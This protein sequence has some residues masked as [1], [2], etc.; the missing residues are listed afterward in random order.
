MK[1]K[2]SF[3]III[4][5]TASILSYV[6]FMEK[7]MGVETIYIRANGSVEPSYAPIQRSGNV[8]T[9]TNN[10]NSDVDGIIVER[11]F[12]ILDGA[13]F[14]IQGNSIPSSRG[15]YLSGIINSTVRNVKVKAFESGILL[16]TYSAYNRIYGNTVEDN[17]YGINCW[18]YAD[19]NTIIG[20]NITSN[21]QTG[22]WLAGSS[23]I[24]VTENNIAGNG[25]YGISLES[26][27]NCSVYHN[28]FN[29]N[30]NQV[31]IYDSPS[32]WDH[33]YPSGGNYWSDYSGSDI[34]SGPGQNLSG[35]DKIGDTKYVC[36]ADNFDNYPFMKL[37]V[38]I[39]ITEL[40]S[41]KYFVGEGYK[42]YISVTVQNQGWNAQTTNLVVRLNATVLGNITNLALPQRTQMTLNFTWQTSPA[43]RGIYTL[44]STV[45]SV[46]NEPDT[47][48]NNRTYGRTV[49]VTIVG[50]V[51]GDNTVDIFDAIIVSSAFGSVPSSANW[52][53]NAD[54]NSDSIV[55]IFDAILLA[56][57]FGKKA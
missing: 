52:N 10:I 47:T 11:N 29:D 50:D 36:D 35:S 20:N 45:D 38:N 26:S 33:G 24:S 51:N 49:K 31:N 34:Y 48:D 9:F 8:Y 3:V 2:A 57:N 28:N 19:N 37:F 43:L 5:L 16:D 4:I 21:S 17:N 18:G 22:I 1:Q 27:P 6:S 40:S 53:G 32:I 25:Q 13:G 15:I 41:S 39:A 46:P 42:V 54:I 7:A 14:T 30:T 56:N 55:D 44:S 23:N 12:T